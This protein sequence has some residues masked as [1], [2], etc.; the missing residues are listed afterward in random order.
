[1]TRSTREVTGLAIVKNN[2]QTLLTSKTKNLMR[3]GETSLLVIRY[4]RQVI[5]ARR[6]C[7]FMPLL[8]QMAPYSL[9]AANSRKKSVYGAGDLNTMDTPEGYG[10]T[11]ANR[12]RRQLQRTLQ[13]SV[14]ADAFR[15]NQ[16]RAIQLINHGIENFLSQIGTVRMFYKNAMPSPR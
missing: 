10:A 13:Y 3:Y 15:Y 16:D 6:P 14:T 12:K 1:M 5:L 8:L 9:R 11:A 7:C 4:E 2:F